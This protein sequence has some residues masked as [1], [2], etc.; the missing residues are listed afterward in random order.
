MRDA[1]RGHQRVDAAGE[2]GRRVARLRIGAGE[3]VAWQIDTD[4]AMIDGE[5]LGRRLPGQQVDALAVEQH[6]HRPL[7]TIGNVEPDSIGVDEARGR[8]ARVFGLERGGIDIEAHKAGS[9]RP[10]DPKHDQYEVEARKPR[11]RPGG[12]IW[13]HGALL[14]GRQNA[15]KLRFA[16]VEDDH[17]AVVRRLGQPV[18]RT[19]RLG[20]MRHPL[21]IVL[22]AFTSAAFAQS[23]T[24]V[25][26]P[27]ARPNPAAVV[28][29]PARAAA[30]ARCV[31][32]FVRAAVIAIAS[33]RGDVVIRAG[34]S[35]VRGPRVERGVLGLGRAATSATPRLS[36]RVSLRYAGRGHGQAAAAHP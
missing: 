8:V 25:P 3:P 7:P 6:Q 23:V 22:I 30:G 9:G 14:A 28:P 27:R 35:G 11:P 13:R 24:D 17:A 21:V 2:T 10:G 29:M 19:R 4:D 33:A 36:G 15:A 26:L 1:E 31:R 34:I 18:V 32:H 16:A 20:L 5:Q 12:D